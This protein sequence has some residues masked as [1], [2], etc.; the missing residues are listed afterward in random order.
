MRTL[1][2]LLLLLVAVTVFA[3]SNQTPVT[4]NFWQ[5]PIY[6]G[7]L[8]MVVVGAGVLG[9]LLTYT[10]S[11]AHHVRQTRQIRSLQESVRA[12]EAREGP[13]ARPVGP[14]PSPVPP[15]SAEET[16]RPS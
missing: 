11:L 16:R 3:L 6:T 5:W 2:W 15:G 12:H 7:P 10:S 8:A 4:V 13:P 14:T 9:V 1:L